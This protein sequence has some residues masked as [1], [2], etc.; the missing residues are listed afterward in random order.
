MTKCLIQNHALD[1]QMRQS[2]LGHNTQ[3]LSS[4]IG[5]RFL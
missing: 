1:K 4:A 3:P 5:L 2:H